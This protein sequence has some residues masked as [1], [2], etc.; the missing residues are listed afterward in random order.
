MPRLPQPTDEQQA[1]INAVK[2]NTTIMINAVAG[3][4]KTTTN[5]LIAKQHRT[6][7]ILLLTYNNHLRKE[8]MERAHSLKNIDVHTFHS[9]AG[10]IFGETCFNDTQLAKCLDVEYLGHDTNTDF[11]YNEYDEIDVDDNDEYISHNDLDDL[12]ECDIND[13]SDN[14]TIPELR[15]GLYDIVIIDESQDLTELLYRLCRHVIR[16]YSKSDACHIIL[17]DIRQSIYDYNGADSRYM[18]HFY[19]SH[20]D[21]RDYIELPLKQTWRL[22]GE[23]TDFINNIIFR[24]QRVLDSPDQ[25]YTGF[26]PRYIF[27]KNVWAAEEGYVYKKLE[28]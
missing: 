11:D 25:R 18:Q 23:M 13:L 6:K 16:N 17:G 12:D 15:A 3:S 24:G 10:K 4:G 7:N 9:F 20:P 22:T 27:E 5:L 28:S 26:K 8:T 19:A 1:I 21:G 2:P 14:E